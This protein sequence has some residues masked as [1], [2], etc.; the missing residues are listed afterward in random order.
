MSSSY[1][2]PAHRQTLAIILLLIMIS[3]FF[4]VGQATRV[5]AQGKTA[6]IGSEPDADI[7]YARANALSRG[8]LIEW[9]SKPD[10]NNLGFNLYRL[11]GGYRTRINADVIPGVIFAGVRHVGLPGDYS[12]SRIDPTGT[13]DSIYTIESVSVEGL[14]RSHNAII[15]VR[16]SSPTHTDQSVNQSNPKNEVAQS[17]KTFPAGAGQPERPAGPIEDQWNVAAQAGLKI[18]IKSDAWYRVTQP[19]MAAAGFSPI[20]DIRNLSL[21]ADGIELAI[22]TSKDVGPVTG[23]DYIEFYGRGLDTSTTDTRIYYLIAGTSPGK[24]IVGDVR[25]NS[26]PPSP[27]PVTPLVSPQPVHLNPQPL[28]GWLLQF[29][30][31][32]SDSFSTGSSSNTTPPE[33]SALPR[34]EPRVEVSPQAS[35]NMSSAREKEGA[36]VKA[37]EPAAK[38]KTE[39]PLKVPA[40]ETIRRQEPTVSEP[41]TIAGKRRSKRRGKKRI[42]PGTRREHNHTDASAAVTAGSFSNT[43]Q[44]KQRFLYFAG[45]LNGDTE[46]YFGTVVSGSPV[47]Q[48]LNVPNPELTADGPAKLEV[49]LQGVPGVF[50]FNHSVNVSFNGTQVTTLN[51]GPADHVAPIINIPVSQLLTGANTVTLTRASS[52]DIC[53]VDYVRL[54]YPHALKA[55]NNALRFS[56]RSTQTA[57]IDG[58]AGQDIRLIDYTDAFTV[59]VI[60]PLMETTAAGY[61]LTVSP[62][63]PSKYGRLLYALSE[64]QFAQ[65]AALSLNQ[66]STLN[67]TSNGA[68]LLIIAHK[69][70]IPSAA[71]LVSLRQSQGLLVSVVDVE[72]VYDEFGFGAHGPQAIKDF[73]LRAKS[74]WTTAPRYVIFLGDA[75]LDP[76]N[77]EGVGNFD[78]VPTKLI[79]ATYNETASDDWLSD[80]DNDGIGDIPSG[81]LPVRTP[82][83]ASL[84]ISKI[85]NFVPSNAPQS[86]LLVADDPTNYYFNFET[87][88]DEVQAQLLSLV[89]SM[90]VVRV[91]KRTDPNAHDSIITNLNQGQALVNYSGHGNVNTWT[92]SSIFTSVDASAAAN[93]NKLPLVL[94]MN[95]LNGY[96]QDPRLEG[97]AEALIKAPNGGA[98]AV[99]AS[100]GETIPDGQHEMNGRLYQLLYGSSTIPLGDAIKDAKTFTNDIDVRRT[101]ILFGDPSMKIR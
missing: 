47:T 91:N 51:F 56:L 85:I 72:D 13:A 53:L 63:A 6:G 94:V 44:F 88:N 93:G 5:Q 39:T 73:L 77:Y 74:S 2:N 33:R 37:L 23:A 92:G 54:T 20:V 65:P 27:L 40:A 43:V 41:R 52:N 96:F 71:P 12:F 17:E 50:F 31:G 61:S 9:Q 38:T 97:I 89:P 4:G 70:L 35:L 30:N 57:K 34:L 19:Q 22:G 24:R 101:W 3:P 79:D 10:P 82:A 76:R 1:H 8:V 16:E 59:K 45:L 64:T 60:R 18:S 14:T 83:E 84:A 66:P 58:F 69:S 99:F 90:T 67:A 28:F 100:S 68:A 46:N 21:F 95:C 81:R 42:K 55:D 29:L 80:F 86:A 78:L 32:S 62:G 98:V 25:T 36:T 15:P 26:V 49:A 7:S 11:Q 87:A 48:T 75:D